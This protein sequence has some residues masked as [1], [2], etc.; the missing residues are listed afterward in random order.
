VALDPIEESTGAA[1]EIIA[2]LPANVVLEQARRLWRALST[3]VAQRGVPP[4]RTRVEQVALSRVLLAT[5]TNS[6]AANPPRKP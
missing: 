3:E 6:P 5:P 4:K 1:L 2:L